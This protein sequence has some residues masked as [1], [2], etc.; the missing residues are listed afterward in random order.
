MFAPLPI[1]YVALEGAVNL[2]LDCFGSGDPV[3]D[4]HWLRNGLILPF[5]REHVSCM[6]LVMFHCI[7]IHVF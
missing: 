1:E 5:P 7:I 4:I 2:T 3:P 6:L